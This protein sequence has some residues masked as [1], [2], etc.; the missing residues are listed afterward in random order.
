MKRKPFNVSLIRPP[1]YLHSLALKEAADYDH[2]ALIEG[3]KG[4]YEDPQSFA[5]RSRAMLQNF[6]MTSLLPDVAAAVERFFATL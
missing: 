2:A 6:Q 5:V 1:T 4:L 3:V